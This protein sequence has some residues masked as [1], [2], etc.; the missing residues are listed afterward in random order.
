MMFQE[1]INRINAL[2]AAPAFLLHTGDLSHLAEL[3]NLLHQGLKFVNLIL[4]DF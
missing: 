4:V 1:A 2:S 3:P